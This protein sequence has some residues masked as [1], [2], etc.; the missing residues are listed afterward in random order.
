MNKVAMV[1]KMKARA[2]ILF[3]GARVLQGEGGWVRRVQYVAGY[4][5]RLVRG[6]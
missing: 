4:L 3:E 5:R 1:K 6:F 2:S